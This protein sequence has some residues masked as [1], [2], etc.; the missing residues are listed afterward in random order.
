M[1]DRDAGAA[2]PALLLRHERHD[3]TILAAA[4]LDVHFL[5]RA[6]LDEP[7]EVVR[8]GDGMAV[9]GVERVSVAQPRLLGRG[10]FEHLANARQEAGVE[11]GVAQ[12]VARHP[13][14]NEDRAQRFA[15]ALE[16]DREPG[17]P[18]TSGRCSK[19]PSSRTLPRRPG[20]G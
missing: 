12:L 7:P 8:V 11:P 18:A 17:V 1:A 2:D 20:A 15:V 9:D 5:A 16:V 6:R 19:P 3:Q 14:R 10:V 4:D 13:A